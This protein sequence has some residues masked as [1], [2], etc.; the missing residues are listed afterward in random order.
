[1]RSTYRRLLTSGGSGCV[2]C[3]QVST[4]RP[5]QRIRLRGGVWDTAICC[6]DPRAMAKLRNR[7]FR[8]VTN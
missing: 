3:R 7:W 8:R 6:R 1:L 4:P 5:Q 2:R